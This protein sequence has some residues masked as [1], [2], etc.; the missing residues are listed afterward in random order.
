MRP[1]SR[2]CALLCA[3]MVGCQASRVATTPAPTTLLGHEH[4]WGNYIIEYDETPGSDYSFHANFEDDGNGNP[5]EVVTL[6][7]DGK[8]QQLRFRTGTVS[9]NGVDYGPVQKGDRVKLGADGTVMV[10]GTERKP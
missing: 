10:N 9:L 4:R 1:G 6:T 2:L 3:F 7:A 5:A 8:S